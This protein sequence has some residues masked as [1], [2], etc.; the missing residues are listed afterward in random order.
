MKWTLRSGASGPEADMPFATIWQLAPS[1]L[2]KQILDEI[3]TSH[4]LL[5]MRWRGDY[6]WVFDCSIQWTMPGYYKA[7]KEVLDKERLIAISLKN[8]EDDDETGVLV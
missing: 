8:W 2:R 4:L 7:G 1:A 3:K 5:C 6:L